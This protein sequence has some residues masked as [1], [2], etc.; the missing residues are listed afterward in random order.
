VTY[1]LALC[2]P[3]GLFGYLLGDCVRFVDTFPHRFVF[4]GRTAGFLNLTGE[5]VSQGELEQAVA[6]ACARARAT[7]ADFTVIGEVAERASPARHVF[8]LELIG[9]EPDLGGLAQQIDADIRRH[10]DDYATHRDA[11]SGLAPPVVERVP[12]GT[13]RL[14]MERRGKLGGQNKVPR[15]LKPEDRRGLEESVRALAPS[16]SSNG[17]AGSP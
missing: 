4:E 14:F 1:A 16:A 2:T 6:G 15:V 9:A 5:H 11:D 13:F 3:S 8:Y 10:N 17:H 12:A 7:L